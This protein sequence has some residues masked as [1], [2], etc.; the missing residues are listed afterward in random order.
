MSV[1]DEGRA[2]VALS[3]EGDPTGAALRD[4][5]PDDFV[6]RIARSYDITDVKLIAELKRFLSFAS[7]RYLQAR[8]SKPSDDP[9]A[10]RRD[11]DALAALLTG[12]VERLS[13]LSPMAEQRLWQADAIASMD[14]TSR[15][16][17]RTRF[18]QTVRRLER[19][20][21]RWTELWLGREE[22]TEAL[23]VLKN[24]AE[25][26]AGRP[27]ASGK[28]RPRADN[29]L[30]NW[31]ENARLYWTNVLGRP[32]TFDW[33]GSEPVSPAARFC[34]ELLARLDSGVPPAALATALRRA[35][36]RTGKKCE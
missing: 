4:L 31:V 2:S 8:K 23:M 36:R 1:T 26:A 29:A 12:A 30:Q 11:L 5:Y 22:L 28:G 35:Q 3:V 27:F 33:Q 18:G 15:Q 34:H 6:A 13:T 16:D 17:G 20:P 14:A 32:F 25:R 9:K 24:Y 21:N 7:K 19:G 10:A